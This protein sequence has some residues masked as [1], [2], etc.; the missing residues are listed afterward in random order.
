MVKIVI[1]DEEK[2][3]EVIEQAD[4]GGHKFRVQ[5]RWIY[6]IIDRPWV[7][8]IFSE[9]PRAWGKLSKDGKSIRVHGRDAMALMEL[10]AR[11]IER[12]LGGEVTLILSPHATWDSEGGVD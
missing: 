1:P 9:A 3:R 10:L 2:I 12:E 4:I 5:D 11:E 8:R 7:K 6:Q